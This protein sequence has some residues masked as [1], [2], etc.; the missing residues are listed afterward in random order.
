MVRQQPAKKNG[1]T[2]RVLLYGADAS[3]LESEIAAYPNLQ[4]VRRN[5]DI[6]VSYGGD[7]TLLHS[8]LEWPGVPKVPVLNSQRGYRCIPHPAAQVI[9]GLAQGRLMSTLYTKLACT[10]WRDGVANLCVAALNEINVQMG[11]IN[12]AVRFKL[13]ING[14][15]YDSGRELLGDGFLVCT[16][17]GSTA[18]FSALTHAAFFEGIGLAFKATKERISHLVVPEHYTM[19]LQITRGPAVLAHDAALQ[20]TE[21]TAGDMLDIEKHPLSATILTCE[22]VQRPDVPF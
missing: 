18:Y 3:R 17:F 15:P 6:I 7:G 11:R 5:P 1:G 19:R 8:E 22:P 2:V 20:F 9:E 10:V 21:L 13:W 16:P 12:S 4:L 14:E